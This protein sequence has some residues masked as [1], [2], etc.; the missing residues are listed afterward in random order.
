MGCL[1]FFY[2][3]SLEFALDMVWRKIPE[4]IV[5]PSLERLQ[6]SRGWGESFVNRVAWLYIPIAAVISGCLAGVV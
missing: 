1:A 4:A 6:S 5:Q 2:D 3:S